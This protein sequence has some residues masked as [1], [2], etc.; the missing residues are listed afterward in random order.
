MLPRNLKGK[1]AECISDEHIDKIV[2]TYVKR[3]DVDKYAHVASMDE[4]IENDY[5]LNIPSY[6][7]TI[8]K[9]PEID[10]DEVFT[11]ENCQSDTE[12]EVRRAELNKY[13]N[14]LAEGPF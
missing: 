5:N 1:T 11:E 6:V 7:D 13:L 2:E 14:S 3:E 12:I 8:R 10:L 9:E 4:I